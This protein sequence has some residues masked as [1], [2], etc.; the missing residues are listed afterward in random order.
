MTDT[1]D[2]PPVAEPVTSNGTASWDYTPRAGL[3]DEMLGA[4]RQA[5]PH[6]NGFLTALTTLGLLELMRR[7]EEAKQLIHEN[8]VT[9]NVYGDPRGMDRPWQLDPIPLIIPP[10]EGRRLE[11][12]LVQ[13][14]RLLEAILTDVY[15]P[16]QLL[17]EGLI[18]PELVF[19][20]P[21][22]LRPCHGIRPVGGRFLH[23]YAANLGRAPD[24]S[25][26]VL[27]DRT[28]SPSGAGYTLEN[29]LVLSRML[30]DVF[31][32]CRV[33][34]LALFFRTFRDTMRA[35]APHNRDN[36]RIVLLT[37]GAFTE[38]YFEHAFLARYPRLHAG[39][40]RRPDG[41]RQSGVPESAR[42]AAA[43]RRHL[44][45]SGR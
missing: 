19:A 40:R 7:W 45:S 16:Q 27:G 13:R 30:P 25:V 12:G 43:G 24:G 32:D 22:F 3:Y 44:P 14:A 17:R 4:D 34:R 9:Y 2:S 26:F 18:P 38:T 29:R 15:G 28:Q 35:I 39:R 31:R 5:R 41:A 42:R 1:G 20:N 11:T 21:G 33:Q 8:G 10:D 37:P 6:W 23:M 36:P